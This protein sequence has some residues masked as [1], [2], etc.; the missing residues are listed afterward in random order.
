MAGNLAFGTELTNQMGAFTGRPTT[1]VNEEETGGRVYPYPEFAALP[2]TYAQFFMMFIDH[3]FDWEV[4]K[5]GRAEMVDAIVTAIGRTLE[6]KGFRCLGSFP[7]RPSAARRQQLRN[8]GYQRFLRY[9][10]DPVSMST[11][12]FS[13]A[14]EIFS[15][16]GVGEQAIDLTL[17]DNAQSGEDSPVGHGW[18]FAYGSTCSSTTTAASWCS[19][20][21][22]APWRLRRT[23][24]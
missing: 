21:T 24:T 20:P 19:C 3:S 6:S 4:I 12:N 16:P 15:L 11:G 14:E 13:T 9:A 23:D 2:D 5:N 8:L 22:G 7:A 18:Q 17:N 10:A 1:P